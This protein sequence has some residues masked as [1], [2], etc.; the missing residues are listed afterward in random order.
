MNRREIITALGAAA[1]SPLSALAQSGGQMRSVGVLMSFLQ[2][3]PAGVADVAAFRQRLAELGWIEGQ[4]IRI[5]FRWSGSDVE[6]AQVLARVLVAL[7]PDVLL[8]RSTPPT[9]ALKRE[10]DAIPIVFVNVAEPVESGFVQTHARPGGNITGFTYFESSIGGKLLQLLKE[11]D[12]RLARIAI[13]YNPQ[14]APFAGLFLRSVQL[15]APSLAL[16]IVDMPVYG[17]GDIEGAMGAFAREPAGGLIAIPDTFT[18]DHR[19]MI[20]ALAARHRLPALYPTP[21]FTP[22]GGLMAYAADTRDAMQ[23]AAGYIDRILR[24]TKPADLPVQTPAKFELSINLKTAKALG[25][26]IPANLLA[27]ADEVIE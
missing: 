10:T 14:T 18:V 23:R 9:A 22:S 8:A 12:P 16:Q 21:S 3:D 17:D 6:R 5:E 2:D 11:A 1:L 4:N 13:I 19:D 27:L 24:G 7:K 25:L 26:T 15:A 20:I